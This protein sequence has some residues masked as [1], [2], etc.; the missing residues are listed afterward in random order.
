M[1]ERNARTL[2]TL[3]PTLSDV[4]GVGGVRLVAVKPGYIWCS[5]ER[6][7]DSLGLVGNK[8]M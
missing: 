2:W 7:R 5:F 3:N 6:E 4:H 1:A 8:L